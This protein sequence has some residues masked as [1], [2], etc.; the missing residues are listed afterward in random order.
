VTSTYFAVIYLGVAVSAIGVGALAD[1]VSLQW[2]VYS[3]AGVAIVAALATL[4][5][6]AGTEIPVAGR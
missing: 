5:L 2:A 3:F 6:V 4:P 1:A